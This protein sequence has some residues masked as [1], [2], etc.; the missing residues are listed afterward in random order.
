MAD[1]ELKSAKDVVSEFVE[2]LKG[3]ADFDAKTVA[4]ISALRGES[5][6][7]KT[8]LLRCLEADRAADLAAPAQEE[9]A[10]D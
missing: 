4:S 6:L 10:D 3:N 8:N 1:K 9:T 2:S 5:K 7:T